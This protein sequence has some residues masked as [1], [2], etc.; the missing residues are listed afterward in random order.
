MISAGIDLGAQNIKVVMLKD[1][2]EVLVRHSGL[3]GLDW[4]ASL[5]EVFQAA[6]KKGGLSRDDLQFITVTGSSTSAI[7]YATSDVTGAVATARGV[8][9]LSPEVMTIVDVGAEDARAIKCDGAGRVTDFVTNDRCAAGSGT[10]VGAMARALEVDVNEFAQ[11]SL[12]STKTVPMNA[13]CTIFAESEVVSLIHA[14]TALEDISHAVHEAI[15][16]VYLFCSTWQL[17]FF[18]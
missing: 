13:Q 1:D 6:L 4:K 15:A 2:K 11:L 5:E 16:D 17:S 3:K 7:P 14:Q 12:R 18:L 10:F 9:F 8:F